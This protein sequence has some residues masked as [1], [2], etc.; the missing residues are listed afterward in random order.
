MVRDVEAGGEMEI[1]VVG[2]GAKRPARQAE[3]QAS[4]KRKR[5]EQRAEGEVEGSAGKRNSGREEWGASDGRHSADWLMS[6][7]PRD[8]VSGAL[9][10][11]SGFEP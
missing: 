3:R 6:H 4:R 8:P 7:K 11:I 2:A 1:V 9:V 10:H 5:K